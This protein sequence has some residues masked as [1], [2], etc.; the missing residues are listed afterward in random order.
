MSDCQRLK[1]RVVVI[2][3]AALGL[4]EALAQRLSGEGAKVV[5]ADMNYEAAQR[6]AASLTEAIAV[7]VNVTD[8]DDCA[9]LFKAAEDKYGKIDMLVS[10]A[11]ILISGPIEDMTYQQFSKVVDVNLNGYFNTCKAVVPYLRIKW[12]GLH[13]SDQLQVRQE[14][15]RQEPAP[16]RRRSSAAWGSPS[17]WRWSWRR[18]TSASI[19]SAPATSWTARCGSTRSTSSTPA[20][21]A[22]QG[23]DPRKVRQPGAMKRGCQ[24]EDVA[25]LMV[26]LLS[27]EASYMTGQAINVTGGQQMT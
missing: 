14:G 13:R 16:T 11:A 7:K 5:V 8:Y 12:Q 19:R 21:R 22:P 27:D 15:L 20:T 3:G 23:K 2:T 1:D 9:N 17:R 18:K 24:Y 26:F 4:G 25:N 10:N 6:V